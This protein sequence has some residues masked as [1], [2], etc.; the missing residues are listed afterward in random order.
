MAAIS[1]NL[2]QLGPNFALPSGSTQDM[3]LQNIIGISAKLRALGP[4]QRFQNTFWILL[5]RLQTNQTHVGLTLYLGPTKN[6]PLLTNRGHQHPLSSPS[7]HWYFFADIAV[8]P[9][10]TRGAFGA[11]QSIPFIDLLR[12]LMPG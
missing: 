1:R 4:R 12:L 5:W 8:K 11:L 6:I 7:L 9:R 2:E 10:I 3:W